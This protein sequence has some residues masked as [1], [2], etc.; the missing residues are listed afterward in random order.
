MLWSHDWAWSLPLIIMTTVLHVVVLGAVATKIVGMLRHPVN[1]RGF[2][3]RFSLIVGALAFLATLLLAI[4]AELWALIYVGIGALPDIKSA[5]LYSLSAITSYG[6]NHV[7]LEPRWHLMGALEALN[8]IML[9]GLTT[10]F[11]FDAIQS[12]RAHH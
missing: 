9:F 2:M 8:G 10:A 12:A 1:S 6:N 4:E 11:F 3:L 7:Y 5:T